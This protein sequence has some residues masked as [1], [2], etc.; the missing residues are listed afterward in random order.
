MRQFSGIFFKVKTCDSDAL[1]FSADFN[2]DPAVFADWLIKLRNLIRLRV[3]RIEI[4]FA[5]KLRIRCDLTVECHSGF[6]CKF[7]CFFVQNRQDA[8]VSEVN[9]ACLRIRFRAE[10]RW[11]A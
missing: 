6:H 8:R 2:F 5:V 1:C 9:D 3:V 4:V 10:W 7:N 11:G